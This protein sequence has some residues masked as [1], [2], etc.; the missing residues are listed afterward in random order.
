MKKGDMVMYRGRD[1]RIQY[2]GTDTDYVS[3]IKKGMIG[4]IR[5]TIY[6][7]ASVEFQGARESVLVDISRITKVRGD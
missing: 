3:Y 2:I 1:G 7:L 6:D 5:S 4:K